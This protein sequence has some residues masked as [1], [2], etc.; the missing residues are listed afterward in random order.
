MKKA[1]DILLLIGGIVSAVLILIYVVLAGVFFFAAS[2]AARELLISAYESGNFVTDIPVG[3]A[4][5]AL[6][7]FQPIFTVYGV[8]MVVFA[9][10]A[11]VN[12]IIAFTSRGKQTKVGLILNIVFG[13]LSGVTVNAVGG[14][15][16][17][18]ASGKRE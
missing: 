18:I 16:G 7:V 3:S 11:V 1:S 9:V 5:E 4:E 13:L 12:A 6:M 15:L 17:L 2:D 8:M 10:M 14:V